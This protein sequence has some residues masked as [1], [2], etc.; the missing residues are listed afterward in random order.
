[1]VSIGGIDGN[2]DGAAAA[3]ADDDDAIAGGF[4]CVD[5]NAG[6]ILLGEHTVVWLA[7]SVGAQTHR[8]LLLP[9][10]GLT[11]NICKRARSKLVAVVSLVRSY[12]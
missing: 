8:H 9:A 12:C 5:G 10:Q 4:S 11:N 6:S 3:A 7:K 2:G 1:M